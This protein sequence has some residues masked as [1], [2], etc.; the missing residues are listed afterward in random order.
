MKFTHAHSMQW[1]RRFTG[2]KVFLSLA[3]AGWEGYAESIRHQVAMGDYLRLRLEA[4]QW[5]VVNRTP[6]PLVCFVRLESP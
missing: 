1:A 4:A 2:L 3:V 6:L 5:A